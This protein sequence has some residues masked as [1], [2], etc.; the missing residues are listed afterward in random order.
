MESKKSMRFFYCQKSKEEYRMTL[1][2]KELKRKLSALECDG[3]YNPDTEMLDVSYHKIHLCSMN[4][5]G[6]IFQNAHSRIT[7]NIAERQDDI[8]IIAIRLIFL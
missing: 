2:Q 3:N 1:Y 6:F 8:P 5:N 7:G 4:K